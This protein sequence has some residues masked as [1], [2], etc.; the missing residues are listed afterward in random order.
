MNLIFHF[1]S[2]KVCILSLYLQFV[3]FVH[4]KFAFFKLGNILEESMIYQNKSVF[5]NT[6]K[7]TFLKNMLFCFVNF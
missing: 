5:K 7:C 6:L 1:K 4:D 3:T 2:E